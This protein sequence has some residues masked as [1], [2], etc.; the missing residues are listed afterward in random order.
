[1][2]PTAE[3]AAEDLATHLVNELFKVGDPWAPITRIQLMSGD[4]SSG[5]ENSQGG[6]SKEPL[7]KFFTSILLER[8]V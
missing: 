2:E 3:Q 1:M 8:G 5:N 7:I 4:W 6:F